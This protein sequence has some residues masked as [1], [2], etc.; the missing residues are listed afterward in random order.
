MCDCHDTTKYCPARSR[1]TTRTGSVLVACEK[2][3]NHH[4][5]HLAAGMGMDQRWPAHEDL[6]RPGMKPL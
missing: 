4:G 2:D 1:R 5:Q 3:T 6:I